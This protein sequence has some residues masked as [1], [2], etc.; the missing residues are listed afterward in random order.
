[1][2]IPLAIICFC[3]VVPILL[4]AVLGAATDN[5]SGMEHDDIDDY[6]WDNDSWN[7]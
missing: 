5:N 3:C 1:M 4:L 2:G 7:N 6:D